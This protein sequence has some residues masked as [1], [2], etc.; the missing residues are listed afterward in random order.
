MPER[1]AGGS[2]PYFSSF[3]LV[4]STGSTRRVGR[5]VLFQHCNRLIQGFS[6]FYV[7]SC[8]SLH[9]WYALQR[10]G[11][12][13]IIDDSYR[14]YMSRSSRGLRLLL[15]AFLL[16]FLS[17]FRRVHQSIASI[18]WLL[19]WVYSSW[20]GRTRPSL[21]PCCLSVCRSVNCKCITQSQKRK[22]W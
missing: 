7:C 2:K 11:V 22:K 3:A 4:Y 1:T 18:P 21:P 5:P 16:L 15:C 20:L 8:T 9:C 19:W 12:S 10:R 17:L 13:R 6:S 14:L